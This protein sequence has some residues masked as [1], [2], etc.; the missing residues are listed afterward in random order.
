[1]PESIT[2]L[3]F[4]AARA[5]DS[6]DIAEC[7]QMAYTPYIERI[8]KSPGPMLD[9]YDHIV[10]DHHVFVVEDEEQI[11]GVL[12]LIEENS[13]ILLDN[14][15]LRPARQGQG[16]GSRLI[17]HAEAEARRLGYK[18]LDLYTHE[19]MTENIALYARRGYRETGHRIEKGYRRIYM[20]KAL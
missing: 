2:H 12:V 3:V 17:D 19:L 10:R 18:Y 13:G 15:A 1:M 7:V 5:D 6:I 14:I 16:I 11:I 20:R 9:N 4:R 8:G